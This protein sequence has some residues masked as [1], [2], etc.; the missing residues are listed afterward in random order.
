MTFFNFNILFT[1]FLVELIVV[2]DN[3]LNAF[4][5]EQFNYH[6]GEDKHCIVITELNSLF[7]GRFKKVKGSGTLEVFK[8]KGGIEFND[9]LFFQ[10]G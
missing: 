8:G 1:V 4:S 5:L 10:S 2:A 9:Y 6:G 3:F 7:K